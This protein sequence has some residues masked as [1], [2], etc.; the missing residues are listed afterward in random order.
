M[1]ITLPPFTRR[2]FIANTLGIAG[3]TLLCPRLSLAESDDSQRPL[4][5]DPIA[6]RADTHIDA[7]LKRFIY[8]TKWPGS[9]IKQDEHEGVNMAEWLT[10]VVR[11]ILNLN[12]RPAHAIVNG[13]CARRSGTADEYQEFLGLLKPLREAGIT[14]HVTIGNHDNRKLLWQVIPDLKV[15]Q[16]ARHVGALTLS[17]GELIFLDSDRGTLGDDQLEC[18][19]KQLADQEQGA[20]PVLGFI[21]YNPYPRPGVRPSKGLSQSESESLL[22]VLTKHK[23]AKACFFGHTHDWAVEEWIGVDMINQPPVGYYFG[24]GKPYG[25]IDM[26]LSDGGAALELRCVDPK[27]P[28]HGE[29]HELRWR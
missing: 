14:V 3:G 7:D 6:L 26:K 1:P 11:D 2:G 12:P 13:D 19:G 16:A 25:W 4:D 15:E 10:R 17:K 29:D 24:K 27:H 5:P 28:R 8:G 18:L 20:L 9:P 21:H 22:K 23:R